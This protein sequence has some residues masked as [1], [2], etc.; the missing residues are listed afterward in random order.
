MKVETTA[1]EGVIII[2]P[3]IFK[4]QRGYFM[5]TYHADRYR[6]TG[7]PRRFVQD[8]LSF[9]TRGTLRGLHFQR[10][11]PQEKLVQAVSGEV[12][13]VAVDVRPGSPTFGRW[14]GILLSEQNKRQVFIPAGFAHG[15]CVLSPTAR[16]LYKCTD[17][18]DPEDEGGI[19]WSDP[20]IG[21]AWP[22][23]EPIISEKDRQFPRLSELSSEQL[24]APKKAQ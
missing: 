11:H 4:D 6:Q 12:F 10:Q 19:I 17:F 3:R 2:E 9:S 21:I 15:F 14:T 8:N 7:F 1:L 22:V 5:E 20:T 18:Y 16:F 24:P 13:D 23:K